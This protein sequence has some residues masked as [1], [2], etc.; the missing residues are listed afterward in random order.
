MNVVNP[1]NHK[2]YHKTWIYIANQI[3]HLQPP[4][5]QLFPT[6]RA[7]VPSTRPA[8]V[9]HSGI[10][11]SSGQNTKVFR[12]EGLRMPWVRWFFYRIIIFPECHHD[13][14]AHI[15]IYISIYLSVRDIYIYIY[16]YVNALRK[17]CV[18]CFWDCTRFKQ[19]E[20][21]IIIQWFLRMEGPLQTW[22][23]PADQITN[24]QFSSPS[25]LVKILKS[26]PS[27]SLMPKGL[28]FWCLSMKYRFLFDLCRSKTTSCWWSPPCSWSNPNSLWRDEFPWFLIVICI[29]LLEG[30]LPYMFR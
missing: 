4:P 28:E 13:T 26:L 14:Y 27:H 21:A 30:L 6:C 10:T 19:K 12:L 23:G 20:N 29:P 18:W 11:K 22:T 2:T 16:I 1:K 9:G 24:L 3:L 25:F 8:Q 15:Y 17:A 5:Q 7:L